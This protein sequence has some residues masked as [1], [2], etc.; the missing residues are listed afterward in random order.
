MLKGLPPSSVVMNDSRGRYLV[1]VD[2]G[3]TFTDLMVSGSGERISLSGSNACLGNGRALIHG[4][5][6]GR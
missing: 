5:M 4:S 1:G 2:V 3:G 6:S